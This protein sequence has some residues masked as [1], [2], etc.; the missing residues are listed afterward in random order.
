MT[1]PKPLLDNR[2][3]AQLVSESVGQISRLSPQWTNYNAS[4]P[5]ITLIELFAWLSEQNMYRTGRT[6]PEMS[7]AFL[8]LVEVTLRPAGVA[9]TVV[10]MTTTGGAISL[11]DRVQVTD[12]TGALTLETRDPLTVS[13][14]SLVQLLAGAGTLLDVTAANA[15][16]YDPSK[17]DTAGTFQPFGDAPQPGAA[18]YLGVDQPLGAPGG[19]V[20]LHVWT[21]TPDADAATL[22]ELQRESAKEKAAAMRDC[23][24]AVMPLLDDW[25]RHYSARVVWEFFT[26][27]A[28]WKTL[29]DVEDD[30]RALTLTGF[31]RFT[32]PSGHVA[33]GPGPLWFVRC[34]LL[35][36]GFECAP[37]LDLAGINAVTAEHAVTIDAPETLGTSQG[38][39]AEDYATAQSPIVAGSTRLTLVSG[40]ITDVSW[41]EVLT[42]DL[43]GAHDHNYLVE[44]ETGGITSG[45]GLRGAV[46]PAGW[47]VVLDYRAGGGE[48]GNIPAGQLTV[49]AQ[50]GWN[51][52]RIP[53]F[54]GVAAAIAVEQPYAAAGGDAA[55]TLAQAEARAITELAAP[56]TTVT[57]QDFVKLALAT[58]GVPVGRANA[59]ANH[60]PVLPCFDAPGS[61]TVTVVPNCPGPA[62]MPRE[63]F[64]QA[65]YRYLHPRRPITTE[66]HVVAPNYV[67]VTV[68]A[69]L[70]AS[71]N[72]DPVQLAALAQQQLDAFFNPLTGGP[73]AT[74]WPIGR[75][76]Y[77]TEVMTMLAGLPNVITVS[78]LGLAADGGQPSCQNLT[79]CAGDL[80]E[81]TQH[82]I[83]V[84]TVG[85][86]TFTRSKERECP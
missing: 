82:S 78:N 60:H 72:A 75:S 36:G 14:A 20:A 53:G 19:K 32:I 33:G 2:T 77:R 49:L 30:T 73:Q 40:A 45:N 6:T 12:A 24:A 70:N 86:T 71:G 3:F 51:I 34:R 76:V 47:S 17:D 69:T 64:L 56:S 22:L 18:L 80:V 5:G 59:L 11:P 66:L 52:A 74:G 79:I 50:S 31:V 68:S 29:P 26:G 43:V 1:L 85:T 10:L 8:R 57:L 27:A 83:T 37:R 58:P 21:T 9:S 65:V 15:Q 25:R 16:P 44:P 41:T 54:S 38:H 84:S 23:P 4:D 67:K 46:F 62:P 39:A 55:E 13:P 61:I 42:W 7:R 28:G 63:G 35:S 81:S 48:G